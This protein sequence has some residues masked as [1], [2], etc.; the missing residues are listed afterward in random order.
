MQAN[1]HP[2]PSDPTNE[3]VVI[4]NG[5]ITN[6]KDLREFLEGEGYEFFSE[7]DTETIV[8]LVKYYWDQHI[9]EGREKPTFR[10]LVE[11]TINSL[12]GAYALIFKS[13][14][15]PNEVLCVWVFVGGSW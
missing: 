7:T 4:H 2:Q 15:F 3:F 1:S 11:K 12:E 8:K 13:V 5:I 6:C 10:D 14:H 9:K